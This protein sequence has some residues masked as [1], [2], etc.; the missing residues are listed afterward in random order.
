MR[1]RARWIGPPPRAGDYLMSALR[2]R[3]A[4][5]IDQVID[6]TSHVS[7]D[8][9]AKAETR[10]LQIVA[11]RVAKEAV[12]PHTRIHSWKWDRREAKHQMKGADR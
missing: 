3:H 6:A 5:R 4:Y 2:P 7:W 10:R 9:V 1:L 12:P 8:P 11:E